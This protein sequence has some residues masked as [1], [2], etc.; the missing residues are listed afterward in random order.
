[1]GTWAFD[2]NMPII[3]GIQYAPLYY[4]SA[5]LPDG[6]AVVI[7]GEYNYQLSGTAFTYVTVETTKGAFVSGTCG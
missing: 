3:G 7:G 6:R 4:C 5:V 1:M 2:S